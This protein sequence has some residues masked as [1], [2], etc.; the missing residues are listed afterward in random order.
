MV[1][2]SH[3]IR[4]TDHRFSWWSTVG[5]AQASYG[6]KSS[7]TTRLC[8]YHTAGSPFS[9]FTTA[10]RWN[11]PRTWCFFFRTAMNWQWSFADDRVCPLSFFTARTLSSWWSLRCCKWG[12][13]YRIGWRHCMS[14]SWLSNFGKKRRKQW[15]WYLLWLVLCFYV[16]VYQSLFSCFP[17]YPYLLRCPCALFTAIGVWTQCWLI[18]LCAIFG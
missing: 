3:S 17:L 12:C 9:R 7:S 13:R 5:P 4:R 6:L 10:E 11:L 14:L 18:C 16:D 15:R 1:R 8:I 2:P